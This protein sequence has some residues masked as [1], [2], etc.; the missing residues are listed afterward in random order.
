MKQNILYILM[1]ITALFGTVELVFGQG[2]VSGYKYITSNSISY[3]PSGGTLNCVSNNAISLTNK[4]QIVNED[5]AVTFTFGNNIASYYSIYEDLKIS[6]HKTNYLAWKVSIPYYFINVTSF[7]MEIRCTVG[8][9]AGKGVAT[10]FTGDK[11]HSE[12]VYKSDVFKYVTLSLNDLSLGLNDKITLTTS[13][14]SSADFYIQSLGY[15]YTLS[16]YELDISALNKAIEEAVKISVNDL[17]GFTKTTFTNALEKAKTVQEESVFPTSYWD[18]SNSQGKQNPTTVNN[19]TSALRGA[20]ELAIAYLEAKAEINNLKAQGDSWPKGLSVNVDNALTELDKATDKNGINNAKNNAKNLI[21]IILERNLPEK[22]F[23]T[24]TLPFDYNLNGITDG[25]DIAYAA[26][27]AL[28]TH[29]EKDCY[30]LYFKQVEDGQMRANQPYI[31]WLPVGLPDFGN[32]VVNFGEEG[33][34]TVN[35][36]TM[37][38]NYTPNTPM[39]GNFGIAKGLL[40]KGEGEN[41]KINAYTAYFIPPTHSHGTE[42]VRAR[43]AVMDEGGNTTYIG[44][45]KDLNGNA[46]EEVFGID[47]MR[48]PEMRKGINIVRQ[49]DGSVRKIVK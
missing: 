20:L 23:F 29:N 38:G 44:E 11:S 3:N 28:V 37:Q 32:V 47:G 27:L 15:T 46:A 13:N 30:T 34:I 22:K 14:S 43:V 1:I 42:N 4:S 6:G 7:K 9:N 12:N 33:S 48:L 18:G 17:G 19:A 24:L 45:L 49:K 26:Q 40:C 25:K 10:I 5:V 39:N 2:S 41:A 21:S 8:L 36:W 31:V 16:Y 35:G